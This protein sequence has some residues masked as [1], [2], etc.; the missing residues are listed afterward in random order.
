MGSEKT[1]ELSMIGAQTKAPA[2]RYLNN[3]T[4]NCCT[5]ISVILHPDNISQPKCDM[6][7]D[8][9]QLYKCQDIII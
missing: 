7:H 2:S 9:M 1:V 5:F 4:L 8:V 6:V 3:S